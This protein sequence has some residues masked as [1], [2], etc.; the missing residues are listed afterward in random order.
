MLLMLIVGCAMVVLTVA[1]LLN[2]EDESLPTTEFSRLKSSLRSPSRQTALLDKLFQDRPPKQGEVVVLACGKGC[3][4]C[5]EFRNV[6]GI[7]MVPVA[8]GGSVEQGAVEHILG[9]G[10]A[11]VVVA[12][13]P[14]P[15]EHQPALQGF[16]SA[17]RCV[18]AG[19][20][21]VSRVIQDALALRLA[22]AGV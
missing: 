8:C 18:T 3:G 20:D 11:G 6:P 4:M 1:S 7:R 9:Y 5:A 2:P 21:E 16:G 19:R 14:S 12:A 13:C 15:S 17:V 10:A 22:R